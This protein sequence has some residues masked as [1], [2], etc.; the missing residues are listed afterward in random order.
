MQSPVLS[1]VEILQGKKVK[2]ERE[3]IVTKLQ[4]GCKKKEKIKGTQSINKFAYRE[5]QS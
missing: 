3:T 5:L 1:V 2:P 4:K